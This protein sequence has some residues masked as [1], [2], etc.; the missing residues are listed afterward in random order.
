MGLI[1]KALNRSLHLACRRR[2]NYIIDQTNVS[3]EA[4]RRKLS[5][6][7]DFQ[8]KC[9]VIIPSE[10]E[11]IVRQMKQSRMD[12]A[13]PIPVEAM[14]ELKA[15]LSIPNVELE[16]IEDVFFV[17]PPLERIGD[18]IDLVLR[19]NEE[20]RPWCQKRRNRRGEPLRQNDSRMVNNSSIRISS[21]IS[22]A[23]ANISAHEGNQLNGQP[24]PAE[25]RLLFLYI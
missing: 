6:F 5:Q 12:G 24:S 16:P 7:K 25:T 21:E 10:E 20:A 17:E 3:K 1:A 4:R 15:M 14:L 9:V 18:A 19:F 2:R 8:R 11:M 13:G 22:S 23:A